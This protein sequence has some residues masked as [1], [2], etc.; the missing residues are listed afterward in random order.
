MGW[1]LSSFFLYKNVHYGVN[2]F[3]IGNKVQLV[4]FGSV[5]FFVHQ[6]KWFSLIKLKGLRSILDDKSQIHI[7]L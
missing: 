6:L 1:R 3:L 5:W 2:R 7:M 4:C